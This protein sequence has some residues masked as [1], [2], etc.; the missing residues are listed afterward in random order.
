MIVSLISYC[1]AKIPL[2]ATVFVP[3]HAANPLDTEYT[4]RLYV[5]LGCLV[6]LFKVTHQ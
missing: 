3:P 2:Q 6:A 5:V 1:G 4:Q